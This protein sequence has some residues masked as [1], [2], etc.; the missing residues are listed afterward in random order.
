MRL[1]LIRQRLALLEP[2]E[3]AEFGR[4]LQVMRD[5]APAPLTAVA[6][7]PTVATP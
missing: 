2:D 5:R 7:T 3:L 4:L 1:D 6:T